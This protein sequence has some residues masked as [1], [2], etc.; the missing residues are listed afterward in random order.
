MR[1]VN[2]F[3]FSRLKSFLTDQLGTAVDLV[4]PNALKSTIKKNI[5]ENVVYV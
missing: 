5:L 3:E 2:L 1:P 4:T